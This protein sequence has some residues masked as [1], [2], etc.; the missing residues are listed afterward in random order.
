MPYVNVGTEK[1]MPINLY[2]E[3]YGEG[4]PVV[5]IHGWP[6]S[7]RMWGVPGR[8]ADR[9]GLPRRRLRPARLR[10]LGQA[11]ERL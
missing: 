3:D 7:H 6:L 2:F 5:L 8:R 9:R 11:L 4:K 1:E 10:Q